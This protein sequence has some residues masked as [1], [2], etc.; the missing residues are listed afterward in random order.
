MTCFIFICKKIGCKVI[1]YYLFTFYGLCYLLDMRFEYSRDKIPNSNVKYNIIYHEI[2]YYNDNE[3]Q[4]L[5]VL[6]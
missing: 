3:T 1:A 5:F 6:M 2:Y 4:L